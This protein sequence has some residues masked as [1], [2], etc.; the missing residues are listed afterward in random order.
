[1]ETFAAPRMKTFVPVR[2]TSSR[3]YNCYFTNNCDKSFVKYIPDLAKVPDF[4]LKPTANIDKINNAHTLDEAL[5]FCRAINGDLYKPRSY[6][7]TDWVISFQAGERQ[8]AHL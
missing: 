1:M 2:E 4:V 5:V 8:E 6:V 7:I 3:E